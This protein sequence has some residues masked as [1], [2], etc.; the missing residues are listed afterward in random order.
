[1]L[2]GVTC[3]GCRRCGEGPAGEVFDSN[4]LEGARLARVRWGRTCCCSRAAAPRCRRCTR[5]APSASRAPR[6]RA[7]RRLPTSGPTA[8]CCADLVVLVGAERSRRRRSS[9]SSRA[10]IAR[11]CGPGAD[12]RLLA[13]ARARWRRF[14]PARACR[15]LHDRAS[16]ARARAARAARGVT[17]SSVRSSRP[18]SLAAPALEQ[19][20]E[21]AARERCDLYLTELKAAA[22]DVVAEQA[23][24]R[25]AQLVFVAQPARVASRRARPRRRARAAA[26]GRSRRARGRSRAGRRKAVS[27]SSGA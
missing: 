6:A 5:I 16:R 12:R 8:C 11:W 19:D 21:L 18:T 25:G 7:H 9:R 15:L 10:R 27:R 14:P 4:V 20:L 24:R 3:V 26:G 23:E 13:R 22:I 2:A 1:M 17:A